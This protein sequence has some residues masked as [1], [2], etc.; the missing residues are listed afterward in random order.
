MDLIPE[1]SII[2]PCY[3]IREV[4]LKRCIESILAQDFTNYE[5]ILIDDG[6][7]ASFAEG[8]V[9]ISQLDKRI[10]T[11]RQENRG[12]S[13]ARNKGIS[14][15][16]GE[17]IAFADADDVVLPYYLSEAYQLIK[18]NDADFVIGGVVQTSDVTI[19]VERVDLKQP[20]NVIVLEEDRVA[21]FSPHFL[22]QMY[23][24]KEGAYVGRGV[25]AKL[26]RRNIAGQIEFHRNVKMGEDAIWNLEALKLCRKVFIAH[27]IWYLYYKNPVSATRRY[28]QE[29]IRH[30]EV[31]INNNRP[32]VDFKKDQEYVAY[33]D[34]IMELL[35]LCYR[36]YL[37]HPESSLDR[38]KRKENIRYLYSQSPWI[39]IR[40]QRYYALSS[41]KAKV[42]C[43]L[44]RWR[45][46]IFCW[47]VK[48]LC[49]KAVG[50]DVKRC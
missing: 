48:S 20:G 42:K 22:G 28:D 29:M 27:Q 32:L 33:G 16:K 30:C 8:I 49:Q 3:N 19:S 25:V 31:C 12:V 43:L 44:Y 7:D 24:F 11:I 6:S 9:K 37:G 47:D 17:Y 1:I 38:R 15:A 4:L 35:K 21:T 46:L 36:C 26:I 50:K 18:N 34:R 13:E 45:L 14:M 5:V 2:V 40:E 39:F 10:T 23:Y 41:R